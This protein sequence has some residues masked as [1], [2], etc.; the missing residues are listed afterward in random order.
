MQHPAL[1]HAKNEKINKKLPNRIW[2]WWT[3]P[4][5]VP[6]VTVKLRRCIGIWRRVSRRH[7]II[8]VSLHHWEVARRLTCQTVARRHHYRLASIVCSRRIWGTGTVPSSFRKDS[9][10]Q[11]HHLPHWGQWIHN[12]KVYPNLLISWRLGIIIVKIF[13][14]LYTSPS[15]RD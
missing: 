2:H 14:L 3:R 9:E 12:F 15:P 1:K 4:S 11:T 6:V 7:R 13:C 10:Q 5:F 8:R